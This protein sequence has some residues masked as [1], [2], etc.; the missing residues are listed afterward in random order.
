M[1]GQMD[2]TGWLEGSAWE[3]PGRRAGLDVGQ[4]ATPPPTL[5]PQH[6]RAENSLD[7]SSEDAGAQTSGVSPFLVGAEILR[8]R[9]VSGGRRRGR[10]RQGSDLP[11]LRIKVTSVGSAHDAPR[12]LR[13]NPDRGPRRPVPRSRLRPPAGNVFSSL[14]QVLTAR[15]S[16]RFA[17]PVVLR[18]HG[19]GAGRRSSPRRC[20]IRVGAG[21]APAPRAPRPAPASSKLSGGYAP[22]RRRERRRGRG[23]G[24]SGPRVPARASAL[25]PR[26]GERLRAREPLP[27]DPSPRTRARLLPCGLLPHGVLPADPA[28]QNSQPRA[29]SADPRPGEPGRQTAAP[30]GDSSGGWTGNSQTE[31]GEAAGSRTWLIL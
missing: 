31:E 20:Q 25:L 10:S 7:R 24:G 14:A 2:E 22:R 8:P 27:A 4:G 12:P 23:R 6:R 5:I 9:S 17:I 3:K 28:R 11:S 15:R 26:L 16:G 29:R 30:R 19:L 13:G 21:S 1:D 18:A